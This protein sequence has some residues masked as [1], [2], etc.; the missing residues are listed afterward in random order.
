M[1]IRTVVEEFCDVCFNEDGRETIAVDRLRFGWQGRDY[2][3]LVCAE[4]VEPLREQLQRLSE[5]A[6]PESAGRRGAFGLR[7][8]RTAPSSRGAAKTAFSL[9][10]TEEKARFRKWADLPNAR[11]ISDS[12][13]DAWIEAGRP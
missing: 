6:N 7:Q 11:R 8:G 12:R 9:L 3:L 10:T 5:L 13:V 4:H 1:P 2:V